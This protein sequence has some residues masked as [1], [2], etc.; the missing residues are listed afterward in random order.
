MGMSFVHLVPSAK[1]MEI[2]PD[3]SAISNVMASQVKKGEG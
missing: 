3:V 1:K 2:V